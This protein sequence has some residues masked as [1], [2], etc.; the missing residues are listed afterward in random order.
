MP[1]G[2]VPLDDV[3]V[4]TLSDADPVRQAADFSATIGWGDGSSS[5]AT[6]A[7]GTIREN[8]DGT[9]GIFG[10]HVYETLA[11]N[12]NFTVAVQD[13]AGDQAQSS[14]MITVQVPKSGLGPGRDAFVTALYRGDLRRLPD[15]GELKYWSRILAGGLKPKAVAF[16]IYSSPEHKALV[17]LKVVSRVAFRNT[18]TEAMIAGRR[19][20]HDHVR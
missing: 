4:A 16:E 8:A 18:Y 17:R 3:L 14:A 20:A 1:R 5:F 10:T 13:A 9:F 2:G 7:A 19:A 11:H 6:A 15:P 12:L